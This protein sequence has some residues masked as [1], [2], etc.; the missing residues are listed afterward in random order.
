MYYINYGFSELKL[1]YTSQ[2]L[3]YLHRPRVGDLEL[4]GLYVE[5]GHMNNGSRLIS[6]TVILFKWTSVVSWN[7]HTGDWN[8]AFA[9]G[10]YQVRMVADTFEKYTVSKKFQKCFYPKG[11]PTCP[12]ECYLHDKSPIYLESKYIFLKPTLQTLTSFTAVR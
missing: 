9:L 10:S 2:G 12:A 6:T 8:T 1:L 4:S 5:E 3:R 7:L 11:A